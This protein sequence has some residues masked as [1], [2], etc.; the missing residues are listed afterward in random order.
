MAKTETIQD[1][2]IRSSLSYFPSSMFIALVGL[3]CS[4]KDTVAR[5]LVSRHAFR[6]V[7]IFSRQKIDASNHSNNP[8]NDVAR[9]VDDDDDDDD[10]VFP[11]APTLLAYA[12]RNWTSR[13]V[14][15]DLVDSDE[16]ES[17]LKR[18]WVLLVAVEARASLRFE[19]AKSK[20]VSI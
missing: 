15:T 20:S 12:T 13:L 7:R 8:N 6:R 18:P 11:D 2:E 4:G 19:R 1:F 14:T 3:P 10:N 16:L 9:D 5:Y 17:F